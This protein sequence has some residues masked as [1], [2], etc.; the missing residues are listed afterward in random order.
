MDKLIKKIKV[1]SVSGIVT[2]LICITQ[3]VSSYASDT[4][5]YRPPQNKEMTLMFMLDVSGSMNPTNNNYKEN[6]LQSLK[7][8]MLKLLQGDATDGTQPLPDSLVTGLSEFSKDTGRIKL[9]AKP[10]NTLYSLGGN[11]QVFRTT[12]TYQQNVTRTI[13]TTTETIDTQERTQTAESTCTRWLIICFSY[14]PKGTWS[15]T[16]PETG[17]INKGST[18]SPPTS[19]NPSW[20]N[21]GNPVQ[22]GSIIAQECIDWNTDNTCKASGWV[23]SSKQAADF[24]NTTPA[25]SPPSSPVSVPGTFNPGTPVPNPSLPGSWDTPFSISEECNSKGCTRK[26][27]RIRKSSL[28]SNKT[29]SEIQTYN[30]TIVYS[31]TIYETHRQRMIRA[32]NALQADDSTPTGYAYAEVAAYLMGQTTKGERGSGFN[33]SVEGEIRDAET[34]NKPSQIESTKKCNSQGIYFLT[35]G[36]PQ[37]YYNNNKSTLESI[38]KKS[39]G[40]KGSSF[41]CSNSSTLG[42]R[43]NYSTSNTMAKP[44]GWD[45]IGAYTKALL[46]PAL[47]PAG[48]VINTAV[49]GFG[50]DFSS[51][52]GSDVL[53]AKDW[54][55]LGE[56]GWY[57]G[58][59][60]KSIVDSV[61]AFL[62]KLDK[63]IPGVTVG[64]ATIPIDALDMQNVQ[65]WAYFPQFDPRPNNTNTGALTWLGNVKKYKTFNN[66]LLDRGNEIITDNKGLLKDDLND[67][68]A[69]TSIT[70]N[71]T[72]EINGSNVSFTV[73]V[74]GALSQLPLGYNV[75]N[76]PIERRIFTDRTIQV[77]STDSTTNQISSISSGNLK[78]IGRN[79][80]ISSS[81]NQFKEDPKRGY[82]LSLLGYN[83]NKTLADN[84]NI[85]PKD[86]NNQN[87]LEQLLTNNATLR[88]MGAVMHSRPI[89]LTQQGTTKYENEVLSYDDRDDLILFGTTQG[90]LHIVKAG[91]TATDTEAGKELFTFV[92]NEMI[93]NQAEAFLNQESQSGTLQYGIDGQ[94]TAYTEYVTQKGSNSTDEPVVTVKGGKQWVYGGL[95][96]GGRSYYALDLTDISSTDNNSVPKLKFRINPSA[97]SSG[98]LSY[99]GQSWSKP[100]ITW[101]NWKGKRKLVMFVG[102]GYDMG[103][104]AD[105][106]NQVNGVGAGVYMFDADNGDLLWWASSNLAADVNSENSPNA[107]K[108]DDM[109][110]SVVSQIKTVDR[111]N[112]G[113]VDH[114]YF[115]DLGGQV[116]RV[117]LNNTKTLT[118]AFAKRAVK[119]LNLNKTNG[120]SP[121]FY[122]TPSFTIHNGGASG[123]FATISLGS[124]D[125]S[126]PMSA[127]SSS[128]KDNIYVIFDKDVTK[129][130]LYQL[131]D[132]QLITRN[133]VIGSSGNT[134]AVNTDGN[135]KTTLARAGW[136]YPLANKLRVLND[137]V[138][139]AGDLYVSVFDSSKDLDA[140]S[141]S[142][143]VRGES[144]VEQFCLPYGQ[145]SEI[146]NGSEVIGTRLKDV[147]L[148]KGNIG[149]AFG[150]STGTPSP[151]RTLILNVSKPVGKVLPNYPGKLKLISQRWYE[152]YAKAS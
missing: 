60:E 61:N 25:A 120:S 137:T 85:S 74:G 58:N 10:L 127:E 146:K 18:S 57:A 100:N 40:T 148:G 118:D 126:S 88:Q 56:G 32:V 81:V 41:S 4:E 16:N 46:N 130:N 53:D 79:D 64:S 139:I 115:G 80:F 112:D 3:S 84:I 19:T 48:V 59:N 149:I 125:L 151:D 99:M 23:A 13:T 107:L 108:V 44:N 147:P 28:S 33:S 101:V 1:A 39:L 97:T 82:I 6:R 38:M 11:K 17:W 83:V 91:K 90:L 145:C 8:G 73:K 49:V 7:N 14:G 36:Q 128:G 144:N 12:I 65:P 87:Q 150:G 78:K 72:K 110:Y 69:N 136:Y 22:Q 31:G 122:T 102:G 123:L 131:T 138:A 42:L 27:E 24:P 141:C 68:W 114:L 93:E 71:I 96:M 76:T 103:Y 98:P 132:N 109:K 152:K 104:E 26:Q 111:N 129:A 66:N 21:D 143:G 95:R 29:E 94:W 142:G 20:V 135:T 9:E 67:Y 30:I 133:I 140:L 124:G 121:R 5:L 113:L 15:P 70:K 116:W 89:L 51:G 2:I 50:S 119:I 92:P 54:G 47:N 105:V 75:N 37:Y 52:T 77:S 55:T 63:Y 86:I 35:D 117:D 134:L 34:Y 62:N 106:Y 45:C 43:N